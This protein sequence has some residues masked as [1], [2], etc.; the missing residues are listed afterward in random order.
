[1]A[2]PQERKLWLQLARYSQLALVLPA[3]TVMGLLIGWGLGKWLHRDWLLIAGLLLGIAA[4]FVELV[5]TVTTSEKKL[6]PN[7]ETQNRRKRQD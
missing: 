4:G 6:T 1:M 5:R 7:P 2:D 3:C